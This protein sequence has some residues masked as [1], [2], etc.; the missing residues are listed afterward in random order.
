MFALREIHQIEITSRCN[1]KCVYC[2][3]Y[4]LPRPKVDMAWDDFRQALDWALH[5]QRAGTQGELNLAGIGESTLHPQFVEMLTEARRVLGPKQRLLF[6]TN[7]LLMTEKL[8]L[9]IKPLDPVVFVSMHK[10]EKAG[11]AVHILHRHGLLAGISQD[12]ALSSTNW[13]GQVK[14][15]V[16]VQKGRPCA[17]VRGGKAFVFA[18]GRI[19]RCAFDASGIGVFATLKDDLTKFQTSPYALCA[20]CDQDVGVPIPK[21]EAVA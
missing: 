14:W 18:D 21:A 13:A 9:A 4:K 11:P 20:T 6:A 16:T 12:P 8:A 1:L 17:W 15:E 19:S 7:G 3:S 10:P 2:P 5:F